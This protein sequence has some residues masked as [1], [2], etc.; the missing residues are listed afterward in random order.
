MSIAIP[1][2][3]KLDKLG[4]QAWDFPW[5]NHRTIAQCDEQETL[6]QLYRSTGVTPQQLCRLR[7]MRCRE[8]IAARPDRDARGRFA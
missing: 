7:Q 1:R 6:E 4:R 8:D 2:T 3:A 5:V